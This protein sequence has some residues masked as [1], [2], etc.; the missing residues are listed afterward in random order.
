MFIK[1]KESSRTII[2]NSDY[3]EQIRYCD[4]ELVIIMRDGAQV[5][6]NNKKQIENL[7]TILNSDIVEI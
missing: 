7:L 1:I 2:I 3:I 6:I 4:Y 5:I